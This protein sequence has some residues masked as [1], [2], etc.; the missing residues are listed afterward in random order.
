MRREI[1]T[2]LSHAHHR[3]GGNIGA[4]L[5]EIE[6]AI[7]DLSDDERSALLERLVAEIECHEDSEDSDEG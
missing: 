2:A 6:A 3:H 4:L 1:L 5:T 7:K